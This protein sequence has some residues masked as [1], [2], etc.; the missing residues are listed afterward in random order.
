[1]KTEKREVKHDAGEGGVQHPSKEMASEVAL[2]EAAGTNLTT[3][4]AGGRDRE[5]ARLD[6]ELALLAGGS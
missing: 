1:M 4:H 6:R 3:E 2:L 5:G